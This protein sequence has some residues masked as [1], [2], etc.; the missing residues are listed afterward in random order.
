MSGIGYYSQEELRLASVERKVELR[1]FLEDE[2]YSLEDVK[3]VF[4]EKKT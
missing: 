2:G 3:K 4:N 1:R